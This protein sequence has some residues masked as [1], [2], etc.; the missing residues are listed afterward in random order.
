MPKHKT[1]RK[2]CPSSGKVSYTDK[3]AAKHSARGLARHLTREGR[4]VRAL[5]VYKCP[6]ESCGMFHL[7]SHPKTQDGQ[8]LYQAPKWMQQWAR[9]KKAD[10]ELTA[11]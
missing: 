5:F 8:V 10:G 3:L 2:R 11:Q 6:D 7:T 1:T 9:T 4:R